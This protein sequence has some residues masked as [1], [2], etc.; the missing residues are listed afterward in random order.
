MIKYYKTKKAMFKTL[1]ILNNLIKYFKLIKNLAFH[2]S[3]NCK[4]HAKRNHLAS[5]QK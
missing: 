3:I 4:F 2:K 1:I 5:N